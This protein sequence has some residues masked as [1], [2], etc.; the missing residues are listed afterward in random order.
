MAL[1]Q[2]WLGLGGNVGNVAETF[3]EAAR[4]LEALPGV[5]V[6]AAAPL[7]RTEPWGKT[8]QPVFLNTALAI[9]TSLEPGALLAACLEVEVRLGRVRRERWGPRRIDIDILAM[10]GVD[11]RSGDLVI[12]HPRLTERGFALA[13]LADLAPDHVVG[14]K[15]VAEWLKEIGERPAAIADADWLGK[16]A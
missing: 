12:P 1:G 7:Y 11:L 10:E 4:L 13:P 8:D 3:R 14:G 5:S 15:T 6:K 2:A 9:E 16:S